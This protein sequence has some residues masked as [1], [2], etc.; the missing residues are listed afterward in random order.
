MLNLLFGLQGRIDRLP[1][2]LG[3]T[4]CQLVMAGLL[5]GVLATGPTPATLAIFVLGALI[6]TWVSFAL[7]WKRLHDFELSGAWALLM[8]A[9]LVNVAM[10]LLFSVL[11]GDT[12]DPPYVAP[13]APP[14]DASRS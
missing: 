11:K 14:D 6:C 4:G 12:A 2:F 9:P 7:T 5:W 8:L 1:Y 3:V 13:G 10:Y